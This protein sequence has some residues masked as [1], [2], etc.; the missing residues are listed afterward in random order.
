MQKRTF[1]VMTAAVLFGAFCL[2]MTGL[3]GDAFI[4]ALD[5]MVEQGFVV[6]QGPAGEVV[7]SMV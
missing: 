4:A 3:P 1:A 2:G 6:L 7:R 5:W